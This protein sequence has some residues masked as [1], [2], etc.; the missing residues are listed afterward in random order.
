MRS[1]GLEVTTVKWKQNRRVM[2]SVGR[3]G[4]LNLHRIYRRATE[5][6]FKILAKILTG[7]ASDHDRGKFHRFIERHLPRELSDGKSR[8][9]IMPPRGLFHD[10]DQALHLVAPLLGKT[11]RPMPKVGWSPARVGATGITWGTHR[12]TPAGP[13]ILVNAVLDAPD[14]P[15]FVVQHIVWHE[16]C[17][18]ASP[19]VN[20]RNGRRKVHG[21]PFRKLEER[22]PRLHQAEE[23]EKKQVG[24]LIKMHYKR[25]G[26]R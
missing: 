23:W 9:I 16:L 13:L 21:N 18:Q 20:G 11:L 25:N 2:A 19:P 6:D 4:V 12:D 14:V 17:H 7:K 8:L 22:F 1:R 10:L 15:G 24:R 5:Q 26:R 3:H